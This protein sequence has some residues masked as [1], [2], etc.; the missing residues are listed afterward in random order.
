MYIVA[1]SLK[2]TRRDH[3]HITPIPCQLHWLLV[4][5]RVEFKVLSSKYL[6]TWL[7]IFISPQKVLFAPCSWTK[8][9]KQLT[10]QSTTD[11]E[12]DDIGKFHIQLQQQV[13]TTPRTQ[14]M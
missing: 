8:Y 5:R 1:Y 14:D 4:R 3:V 2:T 12:A 10:C 13:N 11:A 7:T 6:A 9:L